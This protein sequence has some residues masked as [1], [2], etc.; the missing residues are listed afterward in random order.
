[1]GRLLGLGGQKTPGVDQS[2]LRQQEEE[3]ARAERERRSAIQEQLDQE[4]QDR[5]ARLL[6][7]RFSLFSSTLK[8]K[9]GAG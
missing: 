2:L 9:V 8:T 1:M 4:T 6:G 7:N 3:R 5:A